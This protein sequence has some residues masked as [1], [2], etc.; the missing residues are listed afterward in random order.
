MGLKEGA[1][2]DFE[3]GAAGGCV[4]SL[5]VRGNKVKNHAISGC[6]ETGSTLC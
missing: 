2:G 1:G 4:V 3:L 5:A 6:G